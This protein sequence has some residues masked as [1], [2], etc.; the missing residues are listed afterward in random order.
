MGDI[1]TFV[2]LA[3][4]LRCLSQRGFERIATGFIHWREWKRERNRAFEIMSGA[5][6]A[7]RSA[8][9]LSQ[10]E[11][12]GRKLLHK[13]QVKKFKPNLGGRPKKKKRRAKVGGA[14]SVD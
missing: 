7:V 11:V 14:S 3:V 10:V 4:L 9:D 2:L 6:D 1:A 13:D 8:L 12:G 5:C